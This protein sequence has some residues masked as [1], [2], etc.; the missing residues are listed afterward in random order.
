MIARAV[1]GKRDEIYKE[2]SANL[3]TNGRLVPAGILA[4]NRAQERGYSIT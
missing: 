3:I 4:V 2:L 1:D